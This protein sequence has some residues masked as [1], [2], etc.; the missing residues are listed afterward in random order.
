MVDEDLEKATAS[1]PSK[2]ER[3]QA[4]ADKVTDKERLKELKREHGVWGKVDRATSLGRYREG[5]RSFFSKVGEKLLLILIVAVIIIGIIYAV[6]Y[7]RGP[8]G[9]MFLAEVGAKISEW[10]LNPV[11]L[12]Q[13]Y[14]IDPAYRSGDVWST[15]KT[16]IEKSGILFTEL[17]PVSRKIP[18][19]EPMQFNF[20]YDVKNVEIE[21]TPLT[22]NCY[23]KGEDKTFEI[24]PVN[25]VLYKDGSL[26]FIQCRL[27]DTDGLSDEVTVRGS[28]SFPYVTRAALRVYFIRKG[29]YDVKVKRLSDF[30]KAYNINERLP[31]GA[32]YDGQPLEVQIGAKQEG[33]RQP[34]VVDES[35]AVSNIVGINLVNKW[36]GNISELTSL[37][38]SLPSGVEIDSGYHPEPN[39]GCPFE[40]EEETD[41]YN[42]YSVDKEYLDL[43]VPI[44]KGKMKHFVCWVKMDAD[45]LME[46]VEQLSRS[47]S[48][49]AQYVYKT[50]ERS[51]VV[52][53]GE[54]EV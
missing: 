15:E 49:Q 42:R 50:K 14:V 31:I 53:V 9:Q 23:I 18:V 1:K 19:G 44:K 33:E 51:T 32:N 40:F 41:E 28:L 25:P 6:G 30:W 11:S 43:I 47:Y 4:K 46:G 8:R 37:E 16:T 12:F 48:V 22:P 26:P 7:F 3:W 34:V 45:T 5:G 24:L 2:L 36:E 17:K 10:N 38:L 52:D 27:G 35:G 21:E 39:M 13:Q 29:V 20:V 54:V